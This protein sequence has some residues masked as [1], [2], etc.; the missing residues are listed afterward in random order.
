MAPVDAMKKLQGWTDISV[1][2][3]RDLAVFG[4]QL[5]LGIRFGAWTAVN[6]P[7]QAANW[8]RYWRPEI[9]G[10]I[11]AYRAVTGVDLTQRGDPSMPAFHLRRRRSATAA[12][13]VRPATTGAPA[14]GHRRGSSTRTATP[15]P[16]TGSPGRGTPRRRWTATCGAATRPASA[17]P[18]CSPRSTPTTPS[19]TRRSAGSSPA[20]PTASSGSRSCTP[21]GTA[22]GSSPWCGGPWTRL[23]VLRHQGAPPRRPHQPGGLRGRPAARGCRCSTTR[24]AR[25]ATAE[26]LA[27]E[28]PDVDFVIPHLGSFADDWSAQLAFCGLLADRPNVYTDTSGVRRFDLLEQAVRRAGPHKVLFGIG[29][30]LAAPR[31]GAG[32]GP[33]AAAAAGRRS[34]SSW[35]ATSC[36]S[37]GRRGAVTAAAA[38]G[39]AGAGD[40]VSDRAARRQVA[41]VPATA[42]RIAASAAAAVMSSSL[43][44]RPASGGCS[45]RTRGPARRRGR[46]VRAPAAP[47]RGCRRR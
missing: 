39:P 45:P 14:G 25:S 6:E 32:E 41:A 43:A 5:L 36:A 29:R 3:F 31:R 17:G 42:S 1:L 35:P 40:R 11:H 47:G 7:E 16:A 18:T 33:P 10:Y 34:R 20:G 24:W 27:G 46:G 26:L 13:P 15:G 8:A 23:R 30:A 28:Y 2:H 4:E 19:P 22:A 37:P 12:E 9:Q 44:P 21:S 38:L